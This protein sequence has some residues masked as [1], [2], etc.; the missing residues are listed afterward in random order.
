MKQLTY[1]ELNGI[2]KKMLKEMYLDESQV[3]IGNFMVTFA[4]EIENAHGITETS[5]DLNTTV[6]MD[7]D[8]TWSSESLTDDKLKRMLMWW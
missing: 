5:A 6:E 8:K 3:S 1:D 2:Y 4:R 7:L